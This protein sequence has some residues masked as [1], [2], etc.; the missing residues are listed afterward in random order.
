MLDR[1]SNIIEMEA[2]EYKNN[3]DSSPNKLFDLDYSYT[4]IRTQASFTTNEFIKLSN[5]QGI[6]CK[7]RIVYKGY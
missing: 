5:K 6:N 4:Y 3:V 1:L 2:V 7:E